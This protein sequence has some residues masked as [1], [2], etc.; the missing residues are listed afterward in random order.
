M[1][2]LRLIEYSKEGSIIGRREERWEVKKENGENKRQGKRFGKVAYGKRME[3]YK[4]TCQS[5]NQGP[6]T[7]QENP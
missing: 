3:I 6:V 5:Y 7:Y 4:S 1:E 2:S